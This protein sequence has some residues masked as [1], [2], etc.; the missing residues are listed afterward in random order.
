MQT[1]SF[2]VLVFDQVDVGIMAFVRWSALKTS[3]TYLQGNMLFEKKQCRE[4][5]DVDAGVEDAD[6]KEGSVSGT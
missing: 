3:G 1:R 4:A 5:V 2:R 6:K